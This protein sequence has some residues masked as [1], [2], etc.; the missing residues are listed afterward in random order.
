[1]HG[2]TMPNMHD[3][4]KSGGGI[5]SVEQRMRQLENMVAAFRVQT[6]GN[7]LG[8]N[9]T[10]PK[11]NSFLKVLRDKVEHGRA[12]E[13]SKP[14]AGVSPA[15]STTAATPAIQPRS[16]GA[17]ALERA[18]AIINKSGLEWRQT[19]NEWRPIIKQLSDQ[20]GV[21]PLLVEA[22]VKQESGFRAGAVSK[23]G[24]QGLMQLMP[25]TAASLGVNPQDPQQNL[26]GGI[27]YLKQQMNR[28]NGNIPLALAAY[29]AG[30]GAVERHGGIPPFKETQNYVK[31]ILSDYLK[32]RA[33]ES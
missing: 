25:A 16:F 27:R 26:D 33:A 21:D 3:M 31:K 15:F 13:A 11:Q 24:A 32:T 10:A 9:E 23:T 18:E 22:L 8:T 12:G 14:F 5:A 17:T 20:Y 2:F 30:P 1:M 4:F 19:D 29:N 7:A 6:Q 28:F